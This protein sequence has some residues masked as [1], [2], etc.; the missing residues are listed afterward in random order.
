VIRLIA[1]RPS[2]IA[3]QSGAIPTPNP[4]MGPRPVMTIRRDIGR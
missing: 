1:E 2:T 3:S 4:V